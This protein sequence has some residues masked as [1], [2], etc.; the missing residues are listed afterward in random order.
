MATLRKIGNV[1]SDQ[2]SH[3]VN[4]LCKQ[5]KGRKVHL[6]VDTL[7]HLLVSVITPANEQEWAQVADLAALVQDVTGQTVEL[8]YVDQGYTGDEPA[9]AFAGHDIQLETVKLPNAAGP[10]C[11]FVFV[12]AALGGRAQFRLAGPFSEVGA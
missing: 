5:R 12:A 6:A 4:A 2:S 1:A 7:G 9:E 10:K 8:A 3:T 11:G